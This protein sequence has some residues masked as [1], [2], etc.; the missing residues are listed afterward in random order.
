MFCDNVLLPAQLSLCV[1]Y[2]HLQRAQPIRWS[3]WLCSYAL[4]F[5]SDLERLDEVIK[6][7]NKSPLGCGALAGNP[8]GVDRDAIAEELGFE[9]LMMNSLGAVGD[10]KFVVETM[11]WSSEFM[12]DVSRISEDLIIYGTAEFAFVKLADAYS[13]GS[14]LMPQ[15]VSLFRL[16]QSKELEITTVWLITPTEKFRL[17]GTSA[18][19]I[20]SGDRPNG[21]PYLYYEILAIN[22]QQRPPRISRA[23]ARL[24]ED[25]V[26]LRPNPHGRYLHPCNIPSQNVGGTNA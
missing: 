9:G 7:I 23:D 24:R 18:W 26:R 4:A 5:A 12:T 20:R 11:Q 13:T 19:Q 25:G 22:L 1:G 8:F 6:R 10:R 3:H 2:T 16:I 14:S 15:K 21:W 17:L